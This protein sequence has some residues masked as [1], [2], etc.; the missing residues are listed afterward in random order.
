MQA[1][2]G[3]R[4]W[5]KWGESRVCGLYGGAEVRGWDTNVYGRDVGSGVRVEAWSEGMGDGTWD[6]RS[7]RMCCEE[8]TARRMEILVSAGRDVERRME[9][10]GV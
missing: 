6:I 2:L 3:E 10:C 7:S 5:C 9:K 4:S 8:G 1:V